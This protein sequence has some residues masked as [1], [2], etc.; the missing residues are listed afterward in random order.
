MN[1]S[2]FNFENNRYN[3]LQNVLTLLEHSIKMRRK[4]QKLTSEL[5]M[6]CD[7][8]CEKNFQLNHIEK[9]EKME[10]ELQF[11]EGYVNFLENQAVVMIHENN[12][13]NVPTISELEKTIPVIECDEIPDNYQ[14]FKT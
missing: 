3:P 6:I 12:L 7:K 11:L 2:N 5:K 1:T 8:E 4:K 13:T 10:E 9:M 14:C